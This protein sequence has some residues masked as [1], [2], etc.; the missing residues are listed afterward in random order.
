MRTH[1]SG[2]EHPRVYIGPRVARDFPAHGCNAGRPRDAYLKDVETRI[3]AN[4]G[5]SGITC[6]ERHLG[7]QD[8]FS[9]AEV[10]EA[11]IADLVRGVAR[12]GCDAVAIVCTNMRGA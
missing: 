3:V 9:F 5:A 4:W 8:N 1:Y 2:D 10:D 7:L 12:E 11:T 6:T